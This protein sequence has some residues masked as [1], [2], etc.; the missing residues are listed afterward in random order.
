MYVLLV[1]DREEK[2][3]DVEADDAFEAVEALVEDD[4]EAVTEGLFKAEFVG[5]FSCTLDVR[6]APTDIVGLSELIS[7]NCQVLIPH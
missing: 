5:K 1:D 3:A 6:D 2:S 4:T 7:L